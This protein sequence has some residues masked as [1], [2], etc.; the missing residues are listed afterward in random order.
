MAC[1]LGI[2]HRARN[3]SRIGWRNI[4]KGVPVWKRKAA[5]LCA[6]VERIWIKSPEWCLFRVGFLDILTSQTDD[7]TKGHKAIPEM[8]RQGLTMALKPSF[9]SIEETAPRPLTYAIRVV[10]VY[11]WQS[12]TICEL[13]VSKDI[14][15]V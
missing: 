10:S 6:S 15:R 1:Y 4:A 12:L 3:T 13:T 11:V 2:F 5:F 9:Q 14:I 7:L 8:K